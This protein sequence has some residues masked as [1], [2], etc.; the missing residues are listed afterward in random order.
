[1]NEMNFEFVLDFK[2]IIC[3]KYCLINKF[4]FI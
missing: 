4:K 3:M 2:V 1:M